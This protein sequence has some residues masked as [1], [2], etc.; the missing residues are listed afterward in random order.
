MAL[1]AWYIIA[2]I[3]VLFAIAQGIG[4]IL[5]THIPQYRIEQNLSQWIGMPVTVSK[6]TAGWYGLTPVIQLSDI[7]MQSQGAQTHPITIK[8]LTIG[9]D[10]WG[11]IWQRSLSPGL[12][13]LDGASVKMVLSREG[14]LLFPYIS[15]VSDNLSMP[16]KNSLADGL[17]NWLFKQDEVQFKNVSLELDYVNYH[18]TLQLNSIKLVNDNI[19]HHLSGKMEILQPDN[20]AFTFIAN[21]DG[22]NY[23]ALNGD[24][25]VKAN[26]IPVSLG[27][28]NFFLQSV[29]LKEG[30]IDASTWGHLSHGRVNN[31]E[32]K[33]RFSDV[34]FYNERSFEYRRIPYFNT[35]IFYKNEDGLTETQSEFNFY[36]RHKNNHQVLFKQTKKGFIF[37]INELSMRAFLRWYHFFELPYT[38]LVDDKE[39]EGN[40]HN[41]QIVYSHGQLES[42]S[43]DFAKL[44]LTLKHLFHLNNVKG[45]LYMT[46]ERGMVVLDSQNTDVAIPKPYGKAI[47]FNRIRGQYRWEKEENGW[48]IMGDNSQISSSNI[49]LLSDFVLHWRGSISKSYLELTNQFNIVHAD[50]LRPYLPKEQMTTDF[51]HWVSQAFSNVPY[52]RGEMRI[53]G[54][55]GSFP[56]ADN[57]GIFQL[58]ADTSLPSFKFADDWPSAS[59]VDAHLVI[60]NNEMRTTLHKAN[61]GKNKMDGVQIVLSP[62]NQRHQHMYMHANAEL[63]AEETLS[64]LLKTPLKSKVDILKQIA[65]EGPLHLDFGLTLPLSND[66]EAYKLRGG[67]K[68]KNSTA[69]VC[70]ACKTKLNALSGELFFDEDSILKS[71]LSALLYQQP[72]NIELSHLSHPDD[73]L[74]LK[75]NGHMTIKAL[76]EAHPYALFESL[77]GAFNYQAVLDIPDNGNNRFSVYTDLKGIS[78]KL[79][80]PMRKTT[81][82]KEPLRFVLNTHEDQTTFGFDYADLVKGKLQFSDESTGFHFDRGDIQIGKRNLKTT[83]HDG[84]AVNLGLREFNLDKWYTAL[85]AN[86]SNARHNSLL[87]QLNTMNIHVDKLYFKGSLVNQFKMRLK[88]MKD[89]WQAALSSELFKGKISISN[90]PNHS[91]YGNFDYLYLKEDVKQHKSASYD[92]DDIPPLSFFIKN[93]SYKNIKLGE[94]SFRTNTINHQVL[95]DKLLLRSENY[96]LLL[97]GRWDKQ[98]SKLN[99]HWETRDLG[100]SLTNWHITPVVESSRAAV[101]FNLSWPDELCRFDLDALTGHFYMGMKHGRITHLSPETEKELALGKILSIVSLQT[102][103]RRLVLDFSDLTH[104]GFSFDTFDGDF[105]IKKGI[106]KTK[107]AYIDGTIAYVDI[108]GSINIIKKQYD[109]LL[110]VSPHI[111][112][113]L[114]AVATIAG[115]PIIEGVFN[116]FANKVSTPEKQRVIAYSY[117][118]KGPWEKPNIEQLDITHRPQVH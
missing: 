97:K 81:S 103:P 20:A 1:R 74:Q 43:F 84:L 109:L 117:D 90:E 99:G 110:K 13:L 25:Y 102:I 78:S 53:K 15:T 82:M 29:R 105:L 22:A 10:I 12:L 21:L 83:R 70:H 46:P 57:Q 101:D 66:D 54:A 51:Y 112:A 58:E 87:A 77:K 45:K 2:A 86:K 3:I 118:V 52:I 44:G 61:L 115:G 40:I 14:E 93:L 11:S 49:K 59:G 28:H 30:S 79:P 50:E 38:R 96:Y 41:L 36:S 80:Y 23:R 69:S 116:W 98:H 18:R 5:L 88:K 92:P 100:K 17:I 19:H 94:L 34:L 91:I 32:S 85:L 67:I 107:K 106:V 72:L 75:M 68:F 48:R 60:D 35:T 76:H 24:F 4:R 8:Q 89:E 16:D 71:K 114:S 64:Y 111:T 39:L 73:V 47:A 65:L 9:I 6:V 62:L 104:K 26:H 95:I 7:R 27:A 55:L 31:I 108:N 42:A 63:N 56:Y 33:M 113:T 37:Q